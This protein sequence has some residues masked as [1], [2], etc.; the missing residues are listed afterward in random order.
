MNCFQLV[1]SVLDEA[2]QEI[3]GIEEEKD[4]KILNK[5]QHLEKQY[6]NI[7]SAPDIPYGNPETRFAYIF[8]YV[9]SHAN[10]VFQ[11]IGNSKTTEELFNNDQLIVTCVGGGPGSD[12]VG[13]VKYAEANDISTRIHCQILDKEISWNECW[14]DVAL[15]L[16]PNF[17]ISTHFLPLN[18]CE[19]RSL[20]GLSKYLNADLFTMIY[21]LSEIDSVREK[22]EGNLNRIFSQMKSGACVIYVDNWDMQ[23]YGFFDSLIANNGLEII[24]LNKEQL[25]MTIDEEKTDLGDYFSKFGHPKLTAKVAWRI[26][27]KL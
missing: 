21:F 18:V 25:Q 7:S 24:A 27:R 16:D 10:I 22:A 15:K 20:N 4:S 5:L 14:S 12:L 3:K 9:T 6:R 23:Y 13:I 1:K 8:R 2:Y 26:A 11:L 17:N 19:E